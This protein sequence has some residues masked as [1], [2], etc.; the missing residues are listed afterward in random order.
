MLVSVVLY[1]DILCLDIYN[2]RRNNTFVIKT[3][4]LLKGKVSAYY[5]LGCT[6]YLI[7]EV[8]WA[9]SM[10][11][12]WMLNTNLLQKRNNK[13]MNDYIQ[14]LNK[15]EDSLRF[16]RN[17]SNTKIFKLFIPW[18][19]VELNFS[20]H[21]QM[22]ILYKEVHCFKSWCTDLWGWRKW[23]REMQQQRKILFIKKNMHLLLLWIKS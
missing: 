7:R 13:S 12:C 23:R 5:N 14:P 18:N 21:Q 20:Q 9:Q 1:I 15:I 16:L 17:K 10:K 8:N 11:V 2:L 4:Y 22:H 19:L 3:C 6:T